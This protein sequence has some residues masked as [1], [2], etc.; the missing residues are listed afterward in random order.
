MGERAL[1]NCPFCGS[2]DCR[3]IGGPSTKGGPQFWAGCDHCSGRA[4]GDTEA[5]AIAAWNRR[6]LPAPP[7]R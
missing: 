4:W 6:P 3:V 1:L 5:E 7:G 2:E